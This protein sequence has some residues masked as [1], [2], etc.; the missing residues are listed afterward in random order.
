M[1]KELISCKE[2]MAKLDISRR[3]IYNYMNLGM[4]FYRISYKKLR[5]NYDEVYKWL[6][7]AGGEYGKKKNV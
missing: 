6:V 2:L 3:T 7:K 4:P 1:T 5:F